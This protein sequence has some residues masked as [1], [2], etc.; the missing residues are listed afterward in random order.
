M[1]A[2][3]PPA[4]V[5]GALRYLIDE[6]VESLG[7]WKQHLR[8]L[9]VCSAWRREAL[10]LVY[11]NIFIA[12]VARGDGEDDASDSG[13][14]KDP[15]RAVLTTNID[16]VVKMGRHK[17]VTGL[18][19]YMDYEMG[20]LPFVE[21]ALALLRIVAPRWDNITSL[22]AELISS[23]P[24][25]AAGRAPS[26]GQAV[27][28]ASALAAMVP[29]VTALY[30]SAETEDQL[31]RTFA[32][33]LLSAYAHQLARSSCYIMV[34]PNMP[35]FSAAMTR[36][37]ARMSASPSA[38]CVYAGALT[39][40]HITE[41]PGG[42]LWPL[43]YTSD[44]PAAEQEDIVFASLRR[45]QLV[46][47]DDSRGGSPDSGQDEIYQR[48]AFPSLALL[49]VDLSHPLARLLRH[50][51]LPDTLDKLEIACPRIGS[52]SVRGAQLSARV[53]AQ[54]AELAAG[55]GSGEAGFWAMTSLLFG[56]DGLGGYSQ[57]LVGNA[58][59]MPDP[60]AQRW[61][62]LTKLEIMPTISTEYLLRLI[63]ALPRTEELVV[64]SLALAGGELPQDLPT[65]ATIR[66]LRLN[67]RLTKDSEQ[68][69][70]ALIRRLL[71]RLP[72]VDELFMPSFPPPFYDFLREQAPSH[73]HIAAFLPEVG[74]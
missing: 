72:A 55:S 36:M 48:L 56:T 31:C 71:P 60:E 10:P 30:A 33:T 41:P 37:V 65:N 15:S 17:G 2:A 12:C 5:A 11:K 14:D 67:Y 51:Q 68:L 46:A 6:R 4:V 27:E 57:L 58:S 53:Q 42:S 49:K 47:A 9:T 20:L 23:S 66:I 3:L 32:S 69:G 8:L 16:L 1:A 19:L 22:H 45:L 39:N 21:R 74:A 44:G 62:N 28:L 54:L 25:D 29:R 73:P 64:H 35:P 34:D 43:F 52:A 13:H 61:A 24:A 50:A 59:R 38:P 70:L 63:S 40:L 18:S 7:E 26:P